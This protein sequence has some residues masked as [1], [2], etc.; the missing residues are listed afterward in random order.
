SYATFIGE[1]QPIPVHQLP[2]TGGAILH[3]R[4][5]ATIVALT[6]EMI[7]SSNAQELV[8]AVLVD[9]IAASLDL[10]LF[11][12]TAGDSTRP[13][14]LL[15]GVTPITAATGTNAMVTDLAALATAVAPYGGLDIV[16]VTDPG[17]AIKLTFAMGP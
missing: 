12:S 7:Q 16:Y 13:P 3:P 6:R 5:F 10:H 1:G 14:G 2:V 8:Q 9:A 17:T 11:D 15:V 4:K